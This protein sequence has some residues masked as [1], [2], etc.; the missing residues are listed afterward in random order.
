M[1]TKNNYRAV[2]THFEKA[3][4]KIY[5]VMKTID[6]AIWF[7]S[8]SRSTN[9]Y[10]LALC[11]AI[12]GQQLAGSAAKAIFNRFVGSFKDGV[13][14]PDGILQT[15]EQKLRDVGMSWAKVASL[16]DLSKKVSSKEINLKNLDNL[17]NEKVITELVKVKG[18][19]PW[20]AEMFLMFT[21]KREDVFSFGDLGL[22]NGIKKVYKIGEPTKL[23]IEK[24]IKK[25]HPYK[26]YGSIALWHSLDS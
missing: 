1:T 15:P 13:V 17:S 3:D 2:L 20:T 26:T 16:K 10:F 25:W 23:Q 12:V 22:K 6:F 14:I 5:S 11:R 19:G 21:L 24:I 7:D 8:N 9:D 18:I 4:K